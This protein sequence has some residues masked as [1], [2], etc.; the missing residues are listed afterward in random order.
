MPVEGRKANI[1]FE[2]NRWVGS[3]ARSDCYVFVEPNSL[4]T[5]A[6]VTNY[7]PAQTKIA[8]KYFYR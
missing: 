3:S 8:L 1:D 6:Q 7:L 4:F 2:R 5:D